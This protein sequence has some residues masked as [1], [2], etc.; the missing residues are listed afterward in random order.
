M[1]KLNKSH[2]H[3]HFDSLFHL[4]FSGLPFALFVL[5]EFKLKWTTL[6]VDAF[7]FLVAS[8]IFFYYCFSLLFSLSHN[9]ESNFELIFYVTYNK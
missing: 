3:K 5:L 1:N 9:K 4:H 7:P 8:I 2:I 6:P